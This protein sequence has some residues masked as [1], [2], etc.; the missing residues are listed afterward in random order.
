MSGFKDRWRS[1]DGNAPAAG[2]YENESGMRFMILVKATRASEAG[3]LPDE[4]CYV[5]M[6]DYHEALRAA[7]VLVD[8]NGLQPTDKGWRITWKDGKRSVTDGP[9]IESKDLIGGFTI[10]RVG[11]KAEAV[12]WANRFPNPGGAIEELEIRQMFELEDFGKSDAVDR[13]RDMG[14]A[15]GRK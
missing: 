1:S 8:C 7:G 2:R 4:A 12:E 14:V 3:E 10:I 9:F 13:F 11:S 5:A 15:M 6:A